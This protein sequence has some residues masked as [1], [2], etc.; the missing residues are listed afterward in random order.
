MNKIVLAKK[1]A[2]KTLFENRDRFI[3]IGPEL[4]DLFETRMGSC[5]GCYNKTINAK[6]DSVLTKYKKEICDNIGEMLNAIVEIE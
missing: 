4:Q 6:F 1:Q 2:L 5:L 3:F